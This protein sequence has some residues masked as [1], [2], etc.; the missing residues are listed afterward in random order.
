METPLIVCETLAAITTH[1]RI[2]GPEG[3]R[4]S[5]HWPR[6]KT[7]C[8]MEAS[9]DTRLPLEAARCRECNTK[10]PAGAVQVEP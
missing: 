5:G 9:W 4:L 10:K 8:G 2:V 3:V 1:L 7:L 6:P